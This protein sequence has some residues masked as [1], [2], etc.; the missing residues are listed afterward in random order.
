MLFANCRFYFLCVITAICCSGCEYINSRKWINEQIDLANELNRAGKPALAI[1]VMDNV[2][3]KFPQEADPF[4]FKATYQSRLGF[5]DEAIKNATTFI[6]RDSTNKYC[7]KLRGELTKGYDGLIDLNKAI[8]IDS[9]Y[10]AAYYARG[11]KK[12][13]LLDHYGALNDF[14]YLLTVRSVSR[15]N[16]FFNPERIALI[17]FNLAL[18]KFRFRDFQ[19]GEADLRKSIGLNNQH[20]AAYLLRSKYH[21]ALGRPELATADE[22]KSSRLL[23]KI[24]HPENS[25]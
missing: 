17:Y 14:N 10:M 22:E 4:Y 23:E 16:P 7:Y 13:E 15:K 25:Q 2:I 20:W 12:I 1:E 24:K 18:I 6:E 5:T 3:A 9:L 19:S 21:A 11:E 8:E